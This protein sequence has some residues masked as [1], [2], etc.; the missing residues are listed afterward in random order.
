M[1]I[2]IDVRSKADFGAW[3][4]TQQALQRPADKPQTAG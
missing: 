3:L 4:K 2:V 1:P